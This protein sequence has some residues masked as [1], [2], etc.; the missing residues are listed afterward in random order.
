MK[1]GQAVR[2][3]FYFVFMIIFCSVDMIIVFYTSIFFISQIR[4]C[5]I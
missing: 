3:L 1:Q 4:F 2:Y 5:Y